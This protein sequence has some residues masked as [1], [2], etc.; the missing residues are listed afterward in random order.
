MAGKVSLDRLEDFFQNTD[1]LDSF[2]PNQAG[3]SSMDVADERH[4]KI[5]FKNAI[6]SW[7]NSDEHEGSA[8]PTTRSFKLRVD[9]ELFFKRDCINLIIGPT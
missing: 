5:G 4:S 2:Q 7:S 6:F 3:T 1:L 8:T 9:G